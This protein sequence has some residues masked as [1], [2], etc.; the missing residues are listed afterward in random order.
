MAS[1]AVF[2]ASSGLAGAFAGRTGLV[3]VA[4]K[5]QTVSKLPIDSYSGPHSPTCM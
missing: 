5:A 3:K 4:D 2:A 1:S